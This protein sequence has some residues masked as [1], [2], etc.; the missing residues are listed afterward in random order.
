MLQ[1]QLIAAAASL[2]ACALVT[3]SHG[4]PAAAAAVERQ[5]AEQGSVEFSRDILPIFNASCLH[6][7]GPEVQENRLRLD[8]EAAVLRGGLRGHAILPGNSEDSLLVRHLDLPPVVVPVLMRELG[9]SLAR[10]M[11]SA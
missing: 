6:C 4:R 2:V 3:A 10:Q 11:V 5:P 9:S 8:S 7:H 1:R